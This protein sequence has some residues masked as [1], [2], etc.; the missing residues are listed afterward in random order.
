MVQFV[1]KILNQNSTQYL[2]YPCLNLFVFV[3]IL[4]K[5]N[6]FHTLVAIWQ[7]HKLHLVH[8]LLNFAKQIQLF[9]YAHLRQSFKYLI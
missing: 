2:E 7:L 5:L 3:E 4:T 8:L 9:N 6:S 1:V